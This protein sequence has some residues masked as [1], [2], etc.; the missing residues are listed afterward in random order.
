MHGTDAATQFHQAG[1]ITLTTATATATTAM[2]TTGAPVTGDEIDCELPL[3]LQGGGEGGVRREAGTAMSSKGVDS[4]IE[5]LM[6]AEAIKASLL[7]HCRE[8]RQHRLEKTYAR[9]L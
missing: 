6:R 9:R 4:W 8:P 3:T 7:S 2:T 1:R 5:R